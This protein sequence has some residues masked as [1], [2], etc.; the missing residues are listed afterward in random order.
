MT[1][2]FAPEEPFQTPDLVLRAYRVGDEALLREAMVSSYEHLRVW[3]PWA[4]AEQSLDEA[5]TLVH[6]FRAQW[7]LNEDFTVAIVSPDGSRLLGGCGYHLRGGSVDAKMAEMGIWIRG[8]HAGQG[9]G[10]RVTRALIEWGFTAWPWERLT[11]HCDSLNLAS[12]RVAEKAGLLRE[13]TRR[14]DTRSVDGGKRDTD[15][16]AVLKS[17]WQGA[18]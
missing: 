18:G 10:T 6:K 15:L 7:L 5:R 11:W 8:S 9:L 14:Q 16:F 17:E 12:R 1:T 2:F 13:G 3:M 4:V